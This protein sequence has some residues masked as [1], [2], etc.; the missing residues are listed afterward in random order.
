MPIRPLHD[1]PSRTA[2]LSSIA[3]QA[4]YI[5]V[6]GKDG[7]VAPKAYWPYQTTSAQMCCRSGTRSSEPSEAISSLH[8]P[9]K[10]PVADTSNMTSDG[11]ACCCRTEGMEE[12]ALLLSVGG[13]P[14]S[15]P[16]FQA[17]A[18][19]SHASNECR[20]MARDCH[21]NANTSV[22]AQMA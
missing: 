6:M 3:W 5:W 18:Q 9:Q 11:Q 17:A 8:R 7:F 19:S 1:M 21:V 15:G 16:S 12:S 20:D 2:S 10:W 14:L 4:S 22:A 13:W